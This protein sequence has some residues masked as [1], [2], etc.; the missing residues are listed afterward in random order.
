MM[1]QYLNKDDALLLRVSEL[2]DPYN[3][4]RNLKVGEFKSRDGA[5]FMFVHP[6][7]LVAYQ[8]VRERVGVPFEIR[9]GYRSESHNRRINGS[10]DSLHMYGMAIDVAPIVEPKQKKNYLNLIY[11]TA[12]SFELGGVKLYEDKGFV[13]FDVGA[14]RTW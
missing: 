11:Q 2:G 12:L 5:D 13:H 3:L 7:L 10:P 9:S 6:G 14:S 8:K 1:L 4:T